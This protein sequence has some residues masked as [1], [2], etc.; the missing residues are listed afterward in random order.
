[1]AIWHPTIFVALAPA[2]AMRQEAN[3]NRFSSS[4]V[5]RPCKRPNGTS[6][7]GRTSEK[8]SMIDFE[9]HPQ[10]MQLTKF[11]DRVIIRFIT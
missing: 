1:L 5:T 2:S 4:L 6:D 10:P 9:S 3:S 7:T 8:R 11:R